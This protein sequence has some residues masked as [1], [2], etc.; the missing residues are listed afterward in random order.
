MKRHFKKHRHSN[1][2]K[3]K[4]RNR[5]K[6]AQIHNYNRK[7]YKLQNTD[8][9]RMETDY[10]KKIDMTPKLD[11]ASEI[12]RDVEEQKTFILY[13]KQQLEIKELIDKLCPETQGI[14]MCDVDNVEGIY[15]DA[16]RLNKMRDDEDKIAVAEFRSKPIEEQNDFIKRWNKYVA[17]G[18]SE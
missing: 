5:T 12:A 9:I 1:L 10:M 4:G 13:L 16:W 15:Q 18:G 6:P 8:N 2:F 11:M 14:E 3:G 7:L 17:E